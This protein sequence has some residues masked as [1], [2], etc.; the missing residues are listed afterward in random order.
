M[1]QLGLF[2]I[3]AGLGLTLSVQNLIDT[4]RAPKALLVGLSGQLILLPLL[5][6]AL[7]QVFQP[8]A[9]IAIGLIL[10]AASKETHAG[11]PVC[12]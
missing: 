6:F 5:A 2:T 1:V 7:A 12:C 11:T 3:M 8:P 9:V 4:L 10:L